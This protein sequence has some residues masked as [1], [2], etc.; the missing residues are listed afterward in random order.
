MRPSTTTGSGSESSIGQISVRGRSSTRLT[1]TKYG[2][3][4]SDSRIGSGIGHDLAFANLGIVA[5]A[6]EILHGKDAVDALRQERRY[7]VFADLERIA[8]RCGA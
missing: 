7:R 1:N 3:S 5:R 6:P 4:G 8:G 2:A